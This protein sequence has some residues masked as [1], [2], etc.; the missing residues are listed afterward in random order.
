[1]KKIPLNSR[2]QAQIL[3]RVIIPD[4]N[5]AASAELLSGQYENSRV[6]QFYDDEK[7]EVIY[8]VVIQ[9]RR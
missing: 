8:G 6:I 7:D 3:Q 2:K 4:N 1:M 5:S 9:E